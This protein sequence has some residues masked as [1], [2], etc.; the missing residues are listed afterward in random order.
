MQIKYI[1]QEQQ[2]NKP[3][4]EDDLKNLANESNIPFNIIE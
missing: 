4:N 1:T 2:I 3:N